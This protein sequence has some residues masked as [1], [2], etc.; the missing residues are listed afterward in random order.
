MLLGSVGRSSLRLRAVPRESYIEIS[1]YIRGRR[2]GLCPALRC[3]SSPI[4]NDRRSFHVRPCLR[5]QQPHIDES[6]R[7]FLEQYKKAGMALIQ[8]NIRMLP[9]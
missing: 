3:R 1:N 5:E 2:T 7:P 8:P 6:R 4:I 9:D